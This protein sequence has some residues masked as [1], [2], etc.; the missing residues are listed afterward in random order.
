MAAN[1]LINPAWIEHIKQAL[2]PGRLYVIVECDIRLR[3]RVRIAICENFIP[4]HNPERL[5]WMNITQ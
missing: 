4:A 3:N 2:R 1:A 5:K